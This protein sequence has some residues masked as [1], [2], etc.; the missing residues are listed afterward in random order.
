[1]GAAAMLM[2][3][4][5]SSGTAHAGDKSPYS[6]SLGVDFTSHFISYG[7]DVWGGGDEPSPFSSRSTMFVYGTLSCQISDQLSAFVNV[8]SDN[9]NNV[10]SG[11]GGNIQEIDVNVGA[12]YTMDKFSFTLANGWWSYASSVEHVLDG[13]IA[14]NDADMITKGLALNPSVT[15]HWR[16]DGNG[17][18]DEGV[19]VVPGIK[20]TFTFMSDSKYPISVSVP[21]SV[22]FF[23]DDFQ[24][25]DSGFGY[26]SIGVGASVPLSFIPA[27]YGAWSASANVTYYLTSHDAIPGNPEEDFFVTTLSIGMAI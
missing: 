4:G 22:A 16:Y 27:K 13:T 18:Q 14:Y 15:I 20:P 25:G 6:L 7:V 5:A 24:G 19:A 26:F 10:E 9:N 11:I 17:G 2:A 8:W 12:T 23:S 3:L 21:T 1:M